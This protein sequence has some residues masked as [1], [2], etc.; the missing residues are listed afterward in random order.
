MQNRISLRSR[1]ELIRHARASY[2]QAD[3]KEKTKILDGLI[4]ST[5]YER[6][7]AI[8]VL[9]STN[10]KKLCKIKT[11]KKQKYDEDVKQ[12]LFTVW[13]AANQICGKR[14][15]PFLPELVSVLESRG[16]LSLSADVRKRLLGI[17]AATVDRLLKVK[18]KENNR[19]IST[20]KPGSPL[21]KQITIRTFSDWND[22]TPGFI[23]ADLVAHCGTRTD[24]AFLNTLVLTDIVSGWTEF[25]P[26]LQRSEENV[27]LGLTTAQEL[28]PFLLLGLDTD[29]GSEFINYKL[30]A[31]CENQKITFT[32][33]RP[34]HKNDQAHVEE[35]NGSIV[36]RLVGYDRYE[37]EQAWY[38]LSE[39]YAVLRLYVNFFQ[40]SM[41]LISKKRDGSKVTKR[42]DKAKTPCQRLLIS[43]KVSEAIKHTLQEQYK[44][45]D[46][47]YLLKELERL[48]N[49]FWSYAWKNSDVSHQVLEN[50]NLPKMDP[51]PLIEIAFGENVKQAEQKETQGE[52]IPIRRYR[53]TPKPKK[54]LPPRT[55]RTRK[56]AFENVW[57]ELVFQLQLNPRSSPKYILLG[58]IKEDPEQ[59]N[60]KQLRALQRRI[61]DWRISQSAYEKSTRSDGKLT[62][63]LSLAAAAAK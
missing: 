3:W 63:F 30:L 24:G 11:V 16:H 44:I 46:P 57:S 62:P 50:T 61:A 42:Y 2:N 7:Y 53:R 10:T 36:R 5:G 12:A 38:A 43:V 35:K 34:Y 33:S 39:L 27:I 40:P 26:L 58:L 13:F 19:G 60:L 20:T 54:K 37:G 48:Q 22:V 47:L 28:L 49:Q 14:L 56:D 51:A 32:R 29:N 15:T 41:K 55:W 31:F 6:K 9:N 23:E 8:T 1:K 18:R 59:F 45:L 21:K 52:L 25:L 17:S 4:E